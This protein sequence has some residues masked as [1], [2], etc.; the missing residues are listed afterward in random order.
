MSE[1]FGKF[2]GVAF[3]MGVVAGLSV[4][5]A[6]RGRTEA[7]KGGV[8]EAREI[9][10]TGKDG[11]TRIQLKEIDGEPGIHFFN[12]GGR[13]KMNLFLSDKGDPFLSLLGCEGETRIILGRSDTGSRLEFYD[14]EGTIRTTIGTQENNG[15]HLSMFDNDGDIRIGIG[16]MRGALLQ[17]FDGDEADGIFEPDNEDLS[18]L[19]L[20][21][22]KDGKVVFEAP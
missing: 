12:N 9:R 3:I 2:V 19:I 8:V 1:I 22:E 7:S 20:I 15:S 13:M 14:D 17:Y 4:K 5:K 10:I 16:M 6:T 18:P 21:A 11:R